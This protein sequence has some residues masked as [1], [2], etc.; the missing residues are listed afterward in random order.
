MASSMDCPHRARRRAP[1]R[2]DRQ[3]GVR[4]R[5]RGR[6]AL[7]PA[8]VLLVLTALAALTGCGADSGVPERDPTPTT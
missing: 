1:S 2:G 6:P 7:L 8:L 5:A 3:T 4:V